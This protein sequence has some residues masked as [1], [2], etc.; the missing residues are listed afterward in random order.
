MHTDP[1]YVSAA[2][3]AVR[4]YMEAHPIGASVRGSEIR[5]ATASLE[6]AQAYARTELAAARLVVERDPTTSTATRELR[7]QWL[8]AAERLVEITGA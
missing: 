8:V 5:T 3:A 7:L 6:A 4:T 1:A 2:L